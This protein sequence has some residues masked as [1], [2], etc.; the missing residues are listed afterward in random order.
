MHVFILLQILFLKVGTKLAARLQQKEA[1]T[2]HSYHLVFCMAFYC[3]RK[4]KNLIKFIAFIAAIKLHQLDHA[5]WEIIDMKGGR[6]KE[7]KLITVNCSV[8]SGG[9]LTFRRWE[10]IS[11][12]W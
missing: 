5:R 4:Y 7:K 1:C 3:R 10:F 6:E 9:L 12:A 11:C 2:V 8:F